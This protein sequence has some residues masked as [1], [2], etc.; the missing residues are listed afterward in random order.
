ME[1]PYHFSEIHRALGVLKLYFPSFLPCSQ[2][3]LHTQRRNKAKHSGC[4]FWMVKSGEEDGTV[5]SAYFALSIISMYC[6][7]IV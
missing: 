7:K 2:H 1:Q 6:T 5:L 4:C 3:T